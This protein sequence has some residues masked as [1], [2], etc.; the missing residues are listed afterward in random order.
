MTTLATQTC[1]PRSDALDDAALAALLPHVPDWTVSG[2]QLSRAFTFKNYY[3]TIAFVNALA[4][5]AHSQ[6]HHPE[7][8]VGYQLCTVHYRTH[9]VNQGGGGLSD[10]DFICAAK[11][12]LLYAQRGTAA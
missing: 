6:D 10:N 5:I 2:G 12:D 8:T 4:Y 7:L 1:A 11:A 3:Q 9:S